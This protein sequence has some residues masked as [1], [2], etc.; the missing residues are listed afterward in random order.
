M[1]DHSITD[2]SG[3]LTDLVRSIL[4][5]SAIERSFSSEDPLV[6]IGLTSLDMVSLM[7][8]V[9]AEFDVEIPQSEITPEN[10]RSVAAVEGLVRKIALRSSTG[11]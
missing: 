2:L 10:F 4:A 7:L 1:P 6:E 9:E 5:N 3:R 11:S 8:R